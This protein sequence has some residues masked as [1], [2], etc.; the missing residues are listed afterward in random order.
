[1]VSF[2]A[3]YTCRAGYFLTQVRPR[4]RS[5][6]RSRNPHCPGL[7]RI[8]E[9]F[10]AARRSRR[11]DPLD[12]EASASTAIRLV[13]RV[14]WWRSNHVRAGL[15]GPA[16]VASG[17]SPGTLPWSGIG[18]FPL[19]NPGQYVGLVVHEAPTKPKGWRSRRS[20][21]FE[22]LLSRRPP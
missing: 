7:L 19:G 11:I 9:L 4:G 13:H 5:E 12:R 20:A 16:P 22:A 10:R 3:R 2:P 14:L 21:A 6:G 15:P 1:M 18:R 17:G 8:G